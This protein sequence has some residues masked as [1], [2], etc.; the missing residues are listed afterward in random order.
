VYVNADTI[1]NQKL[2]DFSDVE[3][4]YDDVEPP[5]ED[6]K[7]VEPE[8]MVKK[9]IESEIFEKE[10]EDYINENVN[11]PTPPPSQLI[12]EGEEPELI[13]ITKPSIKIESIKPVEVEKQEPVVTTFAADV[14]KSLE[15]NGNKNTKEVN[16]IIKH[17][18]QFAKPDENGKLTL[19]IADF[20]V[21]GSIPETINENPVIID[22]PEE[23]ERGIIITNV[24]EKPVTIEQQIEEPVVELPD[25]PLMTKDETFDDVVDFTGD[26]TSIGSKKKILIYKEKQ[27]R[28]YDGYE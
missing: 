19:N 2:S 5:I 18:E 26:E 8:L 23:R 6:K 1:I 24:N 4:L 11:K 22:E 25:L 9:I 15:S 17:L 16:R 20:L 21:E 7:K 10:Y 27:K 12:K 3:K 14:I 28:M 13:E